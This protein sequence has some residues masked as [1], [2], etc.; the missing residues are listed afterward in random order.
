M[1]YKFGGK[2]L[3]EQEIA[4]GGCGESEHCLDVLMKA[5]DATVSQ[6]QS[7]LGLII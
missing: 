3:L 6:G 2:Y 4:N 7:F 1:D 5:Q